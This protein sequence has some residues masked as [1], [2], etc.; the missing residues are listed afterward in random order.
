MR[1][2]LGLGSNLGDRLANLQLAVDVICGDPLVTAAAVS[3]VVDTDP[4]GGP[5]QPNFLNAVLIVETELSP[6]EVL[7]LAQ[8]AESQASRTREVRWG[9]RTLDVD[10]LS[11]ERLE[12]DDPSLILP[13]P[14]AAERSFV[15]VPWAAV[16]PSMTVPGRNGEQ[17]T[18]AQLLQFLGSDATEGVRL[19][20]D[21]ALVIPKGPT[22]ES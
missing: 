20:Q 2:A 5:D 3:V 12:S 21:L 19:R 16:S 10:V 18:V 9:P 8:R 17:F 13:H 4:V 11:Y 1:V 22:L 6:I 7:A 14:R 15:L